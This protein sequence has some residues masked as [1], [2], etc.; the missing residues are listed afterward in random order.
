MNADAID[1]TQ[2]THQGLNYGFVEFVDHEQANLALLN[3]NG[4]NILE[5]EIKVNW[6]YQGTAAK[7]DT[8]SIIFAFF[9]F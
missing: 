8:S 6:A 4:R 5:S 7:E 3:F 9:I 2:F 1:E